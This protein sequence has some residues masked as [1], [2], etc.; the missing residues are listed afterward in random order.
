[1]AQFSTVNP[2]TAVRSASMDTTVQFPISLAIA[3]IMM[4]L[5]FARPHASSMMGAVLSPISSIIEA[6]MNDDRSWA[7][8][9]RLES[10][11]GELRLNLIRLVAIAGFYGY[12]LLDAYVL[13]DD[14]AL[15]GNYHTLVSVVT[16]AWAVGALTLQLYL[17][18][19][20]VPAALMYVATAWD[21]VMITAVLMIGHNPGS[22]LAVL[23]VLVVAAAAPRL[24]LPLIYVTTLSAMAAFLFFHGY[25]RFWLKLPDEQRL[26]HSQQVIFLLALA[27]TGLV[28]G[29]VLRQARRLSKGHSVEVVHPEE[30]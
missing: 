9:R 7:D 19:R 20:W 11:A 24:S 2:G 30:N 14:P 8:A 1:V 22:M 27:V 16:F 25:V 10:W 17:L 3:A 4:I 21:L 15:R 26:P 6:T 23:Y 12:H 18:N 5:S 29:Q 13:G 28:T